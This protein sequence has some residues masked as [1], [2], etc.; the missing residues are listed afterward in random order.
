MYDYSAYT[1]EEL[2]RDDY[3]RHAIL[4]PDRESAAFWQSWAAAS[5]DQRDTE[6]DNEPTETLASQ[7]KHIARSP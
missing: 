6:M 3:F 2:A 5:P 4:N 1:I 7:R